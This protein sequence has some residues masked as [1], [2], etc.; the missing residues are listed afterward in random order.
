[1]SEN[2][3]FDVAQKA[4]IEKDSKILVLID[5]RHGVD[6]PGGR[7]QKG[8]R[9][10]ISSM[11]RELEEETQLTVQINEPVLTWIWEKKD[12]NLP[13]VFIVAYKCDYIS[14]ELKLSS[15]HS[16]FFWVDKSDFRRQLDE[17]WNDNNTTCMA[18]QRY[19]DMI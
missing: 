16:E 15:E 8:E 9:N 17:H 5:P 11:Q 2:E 1:M 14:G 12:K 19:F 13:S 4:F 3:V 10:L 18:V 6:L 7:I